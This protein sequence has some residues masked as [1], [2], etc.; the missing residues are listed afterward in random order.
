ML[1]RRHHALGRQRLGQTGEDRRLLSH[2]PQVALPRHVE[3]RRARHP[4]QGE[5][6]RRAEQDAARGVE[7]AERRQRQDRLPRRVPDE[8][9]DGLA[10]HPAERG[11]GQRHE[12]RPA[13]EA[14]DEPRHGARADDG[15]RK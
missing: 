8:Q 6:G 5:P 12:R 7:D 4:A 2:A 13:T 15:A 11:A 1:E 14:P 9:S 10:E 3:E